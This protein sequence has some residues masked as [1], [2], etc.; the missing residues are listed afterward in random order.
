MAELTK[1]SRGNT[2]L[3]GGRSKLHPIANSCSAGSC[4]TIYLDPDSGTLVV[5]GLDVSP[6]QEGVDV[7]AGE[8]LV[9]VPVDLLMEAVRNLT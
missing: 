6:R 2:T 8:S 4:P 5:Q 1:G 7:P 9:R 3:E